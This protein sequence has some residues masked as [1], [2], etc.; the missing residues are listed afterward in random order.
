MRPGPLPALHGPVK[1]YSAGLWFNRQRMER[2]GATSVRRA[3]RISRL[4]V[5]VA[6]AIGGVLYALSLIDT[7]SGLFHNRM[8]LAVVVMSAGGVVGFFIGGVLGPALTVD[9]YLRLEE[10]LATAEPADLL[11]GVGG[12]VIALIVAALLAVPLLR[13]PDNAGL[14][15]TLAVTAVAAYLGVGAGLRR[16][17]DLVALAGRLGGTH[18]VAA[19][20]IEPPPA[21]TGAPVVLD[22]SVLID[23]RVLDVARAGFLPRRLIIPGF[24]LEEM[25]RIADAGDA[26]RRAKGRRGLATV[27]GLQALDDPRCEVVDID[28]PGVPEVDSRLLRLARQMGAALMTTDYMLN[29]LAR[30]EGM[31]VLNLND[32][33]LALKPTVSAGE[34][35]EVT[36][37]KEGKEL[38]QG[39][40]YLEDGTMIVV[41]NGRRHVDQTVTATVTTVIQTPAGRMIFAL[42]PPPA[43]EDG[44]EALPLPPPRPRPGRDPRR[45]P[46]VVKG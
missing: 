11:G 43:V 6:G 2:H 22:T 5:A 46:R 24:V 1:V 8:A 14:L 16:K 13:L 35:M 15:A 40:G 28:F 37:V 9:P 34:T 19:A 12:L 4:A 38:H 33:S 26:L 29:R 18:G 42:V 20:S 39:V 27:E 25:Q 23:G 31:R 41:E 36:I 45:L 17:A 10:I 32:L 30:I 44:G 21:V 7:T 3:R